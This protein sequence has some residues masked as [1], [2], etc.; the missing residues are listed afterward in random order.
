MEN[1]DMSRRTETKRNIRIGRKQEKKKKK[2]SK[3]K[4][5]RHR[6]KGTVNCYHT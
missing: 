1:M 6:Y 3:R 2:D 4:R 5:Q